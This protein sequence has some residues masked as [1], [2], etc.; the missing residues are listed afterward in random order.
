MEDELDL[1]EAS[2]RGSE[3][4]F[5]KLVFGHQDRVFAVLSRYERDQQK[6]EDLAQET[7]V[8]AWRGLPRF[9]LRKI[10]FEHWI[11]RIARNVGL[12]HVRKEKRRRS[13]MS[14]ED[15]GDTALDWLSNDEHD[16]EIGAKEASEILQLAFSQLS[17]DD[18]MIIILQE[19]HG[20]KLTEISEAMGW[21]KV[22]TRVRAYRARNR[23][24]KILAKLENQANERFEDP[25]TA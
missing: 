16:L 15:L 10:P 7:F 4:A 21:S 18:E 5:E 11:S 1:V 13:E 22:S 14:I 8:K 24:K 23:L 2:K 19:I 9:E 12:D 17:S 3:S 20:Q 6:V 25:E